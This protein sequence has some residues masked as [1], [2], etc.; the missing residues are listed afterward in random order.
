[1][2][3]DLNFW[4][5]KHGIVLEHQSVYERLSDGEYVEGLEVLPI[6]Q[7][8]A[9]IEKVFSKS[10]KKVDDLSWE[11]SQGSFQLFT[12]EQFL[13]IDCYGLAGEDM[14]VFIDIASEFGCPLY[15]PQV[16]QRFEDQ[17]DIRN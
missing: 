4:K 3:Y 11:S 14:N 7:L 13:R 8:I 1:M 5:Y 2:S 10:W 17:H 15:D 12:T 9:S 16:G 6:D